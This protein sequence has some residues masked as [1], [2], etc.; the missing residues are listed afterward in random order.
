MECAAAV[1]MNAMSDRVVATVSYYSSAAKK[2][3]DREKI[4]V[5]D[6]EP[7]KLHGTTSDF[8]CLK[9]TIDL[10]RGG[11]LTF[12]ANLVQS[13]VCSEIRAEVDSSD[14][15][16]Q[17]RLR[18]HKEPRVHCLTNSLATN[19]EDVSQPGYIYHGVVLKSQPLSNLTKV[20]SLANRMA[21]AFKVTDW[22]VGVNVLKYR[23]YK[24][25]M[26]WH[27]DGRDNGTTSSSILV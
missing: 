21:K 1:T 6:L 27:A 3:I 11:E 5:G 18:Q 7:V 16:K 10:Q 14:V 17:Y 12:Y 8:E 23:D 20:E 9:G 2:F 25:K 24:D 26:G 22:K 13:P 4:T 19:D 15:L